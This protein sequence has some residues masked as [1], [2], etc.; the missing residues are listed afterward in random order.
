MVNDVTVLDKQAEENMDRVGRMRAEYL[1][2]NVT[3][4]PSAKEKYQEQM[5]YPRFKRLRIM[6]G[7]FHCFG[8][9]NM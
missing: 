9:F 3:V 4:D 1:K 2:G 6:E 8:C 7:M 5:N